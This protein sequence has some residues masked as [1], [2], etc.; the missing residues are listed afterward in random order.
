MYGLPQAGRVARD[1]LIPRLKDDGYVPTS[2]TPGLFKHQANLIYFL[3]IVDDFSI[4]YIGNADLQYLKDTLREYYQITTD[5]AA[6]K[7]CGMTLTWDYEN[8]YVNVAM[9]GYIEKALQ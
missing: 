2:R 6:T 3:L 4:S 7:F 1:V 9:P 5:D 8:G